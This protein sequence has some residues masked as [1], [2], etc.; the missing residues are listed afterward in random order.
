MTWKAG[1]H[2]RD[3]A[4]GFSKEDLATSGFW[5]VVCWPGYDKKAG[6]IWDSYH[7]RAGETAGCVSE[8]YSGEERGY[9]PAFAAGLDRSAVRPADAHVPVYSVGKGI[10]CTADLNKIE[11]VSRVIIALSQDIGMRL[12]KLHAFAS[13]IQ[14]QLRTSELAYW[15]SQ[16]RLETPVCSAPL[17]RMQPFAFYCHNTTGDSRFVLSVSAQII[18]CRTMYQ[19]RLICSGRRIRSWEKDRKLGVAVDEIRRRL[20]KMRFVRP[21]F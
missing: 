19:D 4:S 14:L 7:W 13:G 15:Q 2:Y 21:A 1:C 5:S 20:G 10:T 3:Y 8:K 17:L 16:C 18:C 11:E 12:R 9:D 6:R